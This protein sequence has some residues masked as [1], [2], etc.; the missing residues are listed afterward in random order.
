MKKLIAMLLSLVMIL[1][2]FAGCG[3][4]KPAASEAPKA[5]EESKAADATNAPVKPVVIKYS[6]AESPTSVLAQVMT[7]LIAEVDE[8]SNGTIIFEPYYSNE[9]GSLADVTE[10]MTLGGN[11]MANASGDFYA[12]YGC[13]CLLLRSGC[14]HHVHALLRGLLQ[15]GFRH[16]RSSRGCPGRPVRLRSA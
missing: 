14:I 9:L 13:R 8:K 2:L 11:L 6:T 1:S 10:Q 3:N 7:D 5:A 15:S 16:D 4:D 12:T